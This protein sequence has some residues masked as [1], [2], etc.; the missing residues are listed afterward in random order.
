MECWNLCDKIMFS[1]VYECQLLFK[2]RAVV[3]MSALR[4]RGEH[5][6]WKYITIT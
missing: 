5:T 1:A 6:A 2:G 4:N 3:I